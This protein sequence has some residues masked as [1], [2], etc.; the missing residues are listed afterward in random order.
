MVS[1]ITARPD[2]YISE[3]KRMKRFFF[4][5]GD[6][7][8]IAEDEAGVFRKFEIGKVYAAFPE[9]NERRPLF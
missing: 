1:M 5:F 2:R 7:G 6:I 3:I 4:Q 9:M 8:V